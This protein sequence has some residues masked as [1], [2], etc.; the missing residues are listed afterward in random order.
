MILK[1]TFS[2]FH[3]NSVYNIPI[4]KDDLFVIEV[5]IS[6]LHEILLINSLL[7]AFFLYLNKFFKVGVGVR[8]RVRLIRF[9]HFSKATQY[10]END[11]L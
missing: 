9:Y 10:I 3:N 8:V 2:I 5:N 1:L 11:D 7:I 4:L 6:K